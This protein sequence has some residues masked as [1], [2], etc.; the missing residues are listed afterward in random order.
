M[1]SPAPSAAPITNA[2][3]GLIVTSTQFRVL[4]SGIERWVCEDSLYSLYLFVCS[5]R[6]SPET[7]WADCHLTKSC[8]AISRSAQFPQI[9]VVFAIN[10]SSSS[11]PQ[12]EQTIQPSSPS[13]DGVPAFASSKREIGAPFMTMRVAWAWCSPLSLGIDVSILDRRLTAWVPSL[14]SPR[15]A[16]CKLGR[17]SHLGEGIMASAASASSSHRANTTDSASSWK[18]PVETSSSDTGQGQC[19]NSHSLTATDLAGQYGK[20]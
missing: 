17:L 18:N 16:F 4:S 6:Q 13:F 2:I 3:F 20:H 7:R 12:T 10:G 8:S 1:A 5:I 14:C 9:N 19:P 11:S 15:S